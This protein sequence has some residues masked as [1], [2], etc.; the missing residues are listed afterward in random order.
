[1]ETETKNHKTPDAFPSSG[2]GDGMTL[3]DY[4]AAKAMQSIITRLGG[5]PLINSNEQDTFLILAQESYKYSDAML[6]QRE[7]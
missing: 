2:W 1:M 5:S 3:R 7:L 6:K 4:F